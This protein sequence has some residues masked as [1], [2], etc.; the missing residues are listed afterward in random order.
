M[1]ALITGGSRGIGEAI[2]SK[3]LENS[4]EAIVPT[5]KEL[6]LGN[7]NSIEE[8]LTKF[9]TPID[10]LINN[11]GINE[12]SLLENLSD[13][14]IEDVLNINLVSPIKLIRNLL[15]LLKKSKNARIVNIS[16]IWSVVSKEGRSIYS[17]SKSG[18]NA[19]TRSLA[20]ELGHIPVLV[21]T[22]A[23]GYVNTEL[24]QKNNTI[25]ELEKIRSLIP[26][27]R[28]AGPEEVAEVVYFLSSTQNTYLTGQVIIVDG[29]YTCR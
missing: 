11:A 25:A 26:L 15:P 3:F 20:L 21:N 2:V 12:I 7:N 16:S 19:L 18:L 10:I 22:V 4:I 23:P 29:G 13:S 14:K 1:K 24:T 28:L 27:K 17:I 6:D 8:F 5:R 9:N